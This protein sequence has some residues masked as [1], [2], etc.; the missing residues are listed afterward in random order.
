MSALQN[1]TDTSIKYPLASQADTSGEF[2]VLSDD[3]DSDCSSSE[4]DGSALTTDEKHVPLDAFY[5][6]NRVGAATVAR[7]I[8]KQRIDEMKKY[9]A[10]VDDRIKLDD[11]RKSLTDMLG[12]LEETIRAHRKGK[13]LARRR[14]RNE[15]RQAE[16]EA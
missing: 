1:A 7:L 10:S 12:A 16:R 15:R 8:R 3:D 2:V 11:M 5:S 9:V 14:R 6:C 13:R 4:S